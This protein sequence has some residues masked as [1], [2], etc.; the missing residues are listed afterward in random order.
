MAIEDAVC[1]P[2]QL[3]LRNASMIHHAPTN[4][5]VVFRAEALHLCR[6]HSSLLAVNRSETNVLRLQQNLLAF[7][8][9]D[10]V[11]LGRKD[12]GV[13]ASA[14]GSIVTVP[15]VVWLVVGESLACR[16]H[17]DVCRLRGVSIG[18]LHLEMGR[19]YIA[20]MALMLVHL[21]MLQALHGMLVMCSVINLLTVRGLVDS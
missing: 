7:G 6:L 15:Q 19:C 10:D 8:M 11:G 16:C 18:H 4:L 5:G 14:A 9:S 2:D 17:V 13:L 1:G 12:L 21:L 3:A 20:R